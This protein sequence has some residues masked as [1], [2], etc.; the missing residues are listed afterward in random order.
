M[1]C[2]RILNSVCIHE[3]HYEA[4]ALAL[5]KEDRRQNIIY[6]ELHLDYPLNEE[7][8]LPLEVVMG[9]YRSAHKKAQELYNVEI[10]H[11][12][13]LDRTPISDRCLSFLKPVES[14]LDTVAGLGMDVRKNGYPYVKHLSSYQ[15]AQNMG[16]LLAA[17]AGEDGGTENIWAA[18][19]KLGVRQI[20]GSCR[21]A[22]HPDLIGYLRE[23]EVLCAC[24]S[25]N[26]YS[27]VAASFT[28]QLPL[29][30][31]ALWSS[32][33]HQFRPFALHLYT[34]GGSGSGHG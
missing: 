2:D 20:D 14:Y 26:V 18:I 22:E 7:W 5:A 30:V 6:Q 16:L 24:P 28:T 12:A 3:E 4:V 34:D 23:H 1:I 8:G 11:I 9:C 17:R 13:E 21:V 29:D 15:T 32:G 27:S 33:F 10:V 31:A 19:L 25:G